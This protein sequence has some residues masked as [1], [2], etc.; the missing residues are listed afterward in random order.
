MSIMILSQFITCIRTRALDVGWRK[1]GINKVLGIENTTKAG[2]EER[3]LLDDNLNLRPR[4][5]CEQQTFTFARVRCVEPSS[6]LYTP[7]AKRL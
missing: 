4:K 7:I 6:I 1:I 2:Y 5:I 3:P